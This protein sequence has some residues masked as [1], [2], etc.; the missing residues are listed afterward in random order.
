MGT[1]LYHGY[2]YRMTK[3][4]KLAIEGVPRSVGSA[5]TPLMQTFL[6]CATSPHSFFT[7]SSLAFVFLF[8]LMRAQDMERQFVF[9]YGQACRVAAWA[10]QPRTQDRCGEAHLY[11]TSPH[12]SCIGCHAKAF[13]KQA[14]PFLH[15]IW[16]SISCARTTEDEAHKE[17]TEEEQ[18]RDLASVTRGT[19]RFFEIKPCVVG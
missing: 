17:E 2:G 11:A 9:F 12:Q 1:P 7:V 14:C 4:V 10:W 15:A 13:T 8:L 16:H 6:L 3:K 18:W 19:V 5:P